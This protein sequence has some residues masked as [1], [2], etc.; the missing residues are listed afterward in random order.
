MRKFM[1]ECE[2]VTKFRW[3]GRD[4]VYYGDSLY[5]GTTLAIIMILTMI[6]ATKEHVSRKLHPSATALVA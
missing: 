1:W 6:M 5:L 4:E 2:F 3:N